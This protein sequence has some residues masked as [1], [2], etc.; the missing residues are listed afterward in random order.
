MR[1]SYHCSYLTSTPLCAPP[2]PPPYLFPRNQHPFR[3][4]NLPLYLLHVDGVSERLFRGI[5][6]STRVPTDGLRKV[7]DS[8]NGEGSTQSGV[9]KDGVGLFR[10]NEKALRFYESLA[11]KRMS[12]RVVLKVGRE[13][14]EALTKEQ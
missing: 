2:P 10:G 3:S 12:D 1:F 13:E 5:V 14:I 7:V 4:R 9:L 11:A 6:R 8:G